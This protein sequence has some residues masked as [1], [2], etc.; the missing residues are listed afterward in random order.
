[1]KSRNLYSGGHVKRL[2]GGDRDVVA[3]SRLWAL[4]AGIALLNVGCGRA[5]KQSGQ[6]PARPYTIQVAVNGGE[7]IVLT[8]STSEFQIQ[9]SGGVQAFLLRGR[10]KFSLD[11]P[12]AGAAEGGEVTSGGKE[13]NFVL[14]VGRAKVMEASGKMGSGKRIEIPAS[15]SS[16]MGL[17]PTIQIEVYDDFPNLLLSSVQYKNNGSADVQIDR[18]VEQQH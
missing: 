12:R 2:F 7:P 5:P 16:N 17:K 18:V 11:D 3:L 9:P 14:D 10:K 1:M 6:T 15:A 13:L 4:I 8:T